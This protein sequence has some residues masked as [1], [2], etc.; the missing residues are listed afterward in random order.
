MPY[1]IQK[2]ELEKHK[3]HRL[4]HKINE[5]ILEVNLLMVMI[6]KI[7]LMDTRLKAEPMIMPIMPGEVHIGLCPVCYEEGKMEVYGEDQR[8]CNQHYFRST[9]T[10]EAMTRIA[11]IK[12]Q[13][14]EEG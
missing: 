7:R 12:E 10:R 2:I 1:Q 13:R 14:H 9:A 5:V 6:D 3:D 11:G 8:C 4:V